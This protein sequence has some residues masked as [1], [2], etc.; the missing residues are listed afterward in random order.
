MKFMKQVIS[1]A[2]VLALLC[3][4]MPLG[5]RAE[6]T[7][8]AETVIEVTAAEETVAAETVAEETIAAETVAEETV[9]AETVAEETVA[10]E[11]VA[12][13]TVAEETVAEETVAEE[14]VA[15]ETVAEETVAEETVAEEAVVEETFASE[16]VTAETVA[17][18]AAADDLLPD[19]LEQF[20][21]TPSSLINSFFP[22][23]VTEGKFVLAP[24]PRAQTYAN[25]VY[26]TT[27]D[28]AAAVLREQMKDRV[29]ESVVYINVNVNKVD[30]EYVTDLA[31]EI[32][33][34]AVEHTGVP[35]E[36]DYLYWSGSYDGGR[37]FYETVQGG[38][39][40][41]LYYNFSF[42]TTAAEEA[43]LD[44][45][46]DSLL[47]ELNLSGKSDYEKIKG[48]YDYICTHLDPVDSDDARDHTPYSALVN[49]IAGYTGFGVLMY[50]LSLELG[51]DC[52]VIPGKIVYDDGSEL[53]NFW[54][55]VE[56][57]GLYYNLDSVMD[58]LNYENTNGDYVF[59]LRGASAF[60]GNYVRE[61][62]WNTSEFHSVYPMSSSDYVP[63]T[64]SYTAVVTKPTCTQKGYTTYTCSCG[65]SYTGK[66]VAALGHTWDNG[67]VTKEPTASAPGVKT[68]TC[69]VCKA[70]KTE[71]FVTSN[72]IR[73]S[74][75]DRVKTAIS[76][77][78]ALMDC[79][80]VDKFD[81]VIIATGVNEKFADALSGSYLANMKKAPILLYTGSSLS[82]QNVKVIQERMKSNG[83]VY[84]L[85]GTGAIPESVEETLAGYNVK[86]LSGKSRYE[87]NLA[88]LKE[89]GVSGAKEILIATGTNFADSL[90]ASAVGLPLMLVNGKGTGLNAAQIEF[91]RSVSGKK[92]T[93][94]GGDGAV[95]EEM[96]AAIE[97]ATG[98]A[99]ARISG[100]TRYNTSVL[101]AQ[102][103]FPNADAALITYAKNFPD[104]LA[105]GPLAYAM[106][107]PLLLTSA[108]QE[109]VANEYIKAEGID[110]GCVLGGDSAVSDATARKVFGLPANA[111]IE[112]VYY[113][114]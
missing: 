102:K 98:S 17:A 33:S 19:G 45:R 50:R 113:T 74:G 7:V 91:L 22:D 70:T 15:E 72:V 88:I 1:L 100:K 30:D 93:I 44:S 71:E 38:I 8:P 21:Q 53:P 78:N 94:I 6:E 83:T 31:N 56:M 77:A 106:K 57:D 90:S 75:K 29:S 12:E 101:I 112:R 24:S 37:Y 54:N 5:T 97:A 25:P 105:G 76:V 11:T 3:G 61:S 4:F 92:I 68:Y 63:H 69:T 47:S 23:R 28:E 43:A 110:I 49:G 42:L 79:R 32:L 82:Q 89:A 27:L 2:L 60:S 20:M 46:V 73:I 66:E 114:Q 87:T 107:S 40:L 103:Y 85:G 18:E 36:G 35:T 58:A 51:V 26:V 64:H 62:A 80:G 16:A 13:E 86:R 52:R 104:G 59:F 10:E 65:Y 99:A 9:A 95:S 96:K 109:S 81:A 39:N 41:S 55:I 84:I 108:G 67:T 34:I 111:E 48:I 14:T